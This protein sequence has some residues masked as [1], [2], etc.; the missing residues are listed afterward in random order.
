MGA[1]PQLE[2]MALRLVHHEGGVT[3]AAENVVEEE[4]RAAVA[5]RMV[6]EEAVCKISQDHKT[7]L[8]VQKQLR[9]ALCDRTESCQARRKA[10]IRNLKQQATQQKRR[11]LMWKCVSSA[12]VQ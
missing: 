1:F 9:R 7:H 12:L 2:A 6:E 10:K 8:G 5:G 3:Q 11:T 4:V